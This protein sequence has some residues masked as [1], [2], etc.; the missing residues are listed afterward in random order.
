MGKI[1][2]VAL[3][4]LGLGGGLGAGLL[5]RPI[6]DTADHTTGDKGDAHGAADESEEGLREDEQPVRRASS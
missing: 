2:P 1:L 3:A 6:P 5:L 4:V